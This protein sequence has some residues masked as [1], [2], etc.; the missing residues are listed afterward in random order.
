M[1]FGLGVIGG[2]NGP[3]FDLGLGGFGLPGINLPDIDLNG[4]DFDVNIDGA[5]YYNNAITVETQVFEKDE[6]APVPVPDT[7]DTDFRYPP[8]NEHSTD[9]IS[10]DPTEHVRPHTVDPTVHPVVYPTVQPVVQPVV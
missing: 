8:E 3:N 2:L 9:P 10:V 4:P 5:G 1:L 6:A 7:P